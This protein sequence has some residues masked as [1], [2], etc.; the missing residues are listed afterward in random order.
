[1]DIQSN[2]MQKKVF[3]DFLDDGYTISIKVYTDKG[4]RV[5]ISEVTYEELTKDNFEWG[6]LKSAVNLKSFLESC[7]KSRNPSKFQLIEKID[8]CE[9][10]FNISPLET[11]ESFLKI[12]VLEK[13]V[14]IETLVKYVENRFNSIESEMLKKTDFICLKESKLLNK[15]MMK[16]ISNWIQP[17]SEKIEF[18]LIYVASVDGFTSSVFHEKCDNQ[19]PTLTVIKSTS[20]TFL[21]GGYTPISWNSSNSYLEDDSLKCFIFTISS[22][23][24]NYAKKQI[25]TKGKA[26]YCHPSYGPT[27]GSGHDLYIANSSNASTNSYHRYSNYGDGYLKIAPDNFQTVEIEVFKI[28]F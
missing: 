10:F 19:G 7:Y 18:S 28:I 12:V 5:F 1:M 23:C 15:E 14:N 21:F 24:L 25:I 16:I 27:F 4:I 13:K 8:K 3:F 2:E 17:F 6:I 22:N 26:I 9:L 11:T 20:G